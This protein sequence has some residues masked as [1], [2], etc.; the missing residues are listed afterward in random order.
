MTITGKLQ[1]HRLRELAIEPL[2]PHRAP[3]V[4]KA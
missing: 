3:Q 4:T 2:G 1:K